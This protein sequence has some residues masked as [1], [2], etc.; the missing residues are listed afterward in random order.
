V[1]ILILHRKQISQIL[2][3]ALT[4]LAGGMIYIIF[5]SDSLLMFDWFSYI[6]VDKQISFLREK[7][8]DTSIYLWVK[9]N[10]PAALWLFSYMYCIN[11]IWGRTKYE[12]LKIVFLWTLPFVAVLSELLQL[13]G[14][15]SGTFD[16]LDL[17]AYLL[18]IILFIILPHTNYE[19]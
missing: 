17:I 14:F 13:C 10:L 1:E 15:I 16:V 4:L 11:A 8:G 2:L 9:Y 19:N 5:R 3:S 7:F 6:G 18:A 12:R